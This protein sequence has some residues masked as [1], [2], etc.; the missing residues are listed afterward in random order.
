MS[1]S[2]AAR[3]QQETR[4]NWILRAGAWNEQADHLARL[5]RGLNEPLIA[6][7]GVAPGRHV[8]DIASG[9]GEPAISMAA[10]VGPE[11][12]VT[13]T[14]LVAEMLAG[15]ERRAKD[16][17]VTNMAFQVTPMEELPFD[18][19]SFDAVTCRL[20]LMYTPS[21]ERALG[22]ARRVLRPGARAAFLVWGPKADNSQF[23]IVDR[24]LGEVAGIDPHEGAFTPTR[25]GD[26]GAL[27]KIFQ[28]AGFSAWEEQELRFSPRVDLD[29]NFW[30]P[31]LALRLGAR[32]GEM[33]DGERQ[34][35]DDAMRQAYVELLDGDRVQLR[36]HARIGVG[37]V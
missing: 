18:D 19:D 8:L 35:I 3:Q 1:Q 22:Q 26:D 24:V 27:N 9:V 21:P 37:T 36:V 7:A 33:D 12:T 10:L 29:S 6:A 4:Q 34:R 20:G 13:A 28:A 2:E 25:L 17:G 16:Q 11:G 31:Q 15:T 14:D 5:A 23:G 30:R 32:L